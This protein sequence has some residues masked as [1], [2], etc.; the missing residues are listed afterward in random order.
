MASSEVGGD[1]LAA[2]SS[3]YPCGIPQQ[4]TETQT[5]QKRSSSVDEI[6]S[7]DEPYN[8][9]K[10]KVAVI[11]CEEETAEDDDKSDDLS[12]EEALPLMQ[13]CRRMLLDSLGFDVDL[14]VAKKIPKKYLGDFPCPI[15]LL[16]AD[17]R[18]KHIRKAKACARAAID[19]YNNLKEGRNLHLIRILKANTLPASYMYFLTLEVEDRSVTYARPYPVFICRANAAAG[20]HEDSPTV[21]P[22]LMR[23]PEGTKE[24]LT[25]PPWCFQ[26]R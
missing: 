14:D 25:P 16:P 2:A 8:Y 23:T 1:V 3:P 17:K 21:M 10:Q 26:F 7:A 19:A 13:Q 12:I 24:Y 18:H 22:L 4:G 11:V 6:P 5:Q 15:R 20:R 9:K